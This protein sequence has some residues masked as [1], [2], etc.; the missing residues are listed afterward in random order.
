MSDRIVSETYIQLLLA[1]YS[2]YIFNAMRKHST[3]MGA[4]EWYALNKDKSVEQLNEET[5]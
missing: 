5:N 4:R 1:A 2:I 3:P